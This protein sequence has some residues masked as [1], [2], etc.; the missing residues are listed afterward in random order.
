[1]VK[2]RMKNKQPIIWGCF[3]RLFGK[4]NW[5][6]QGLTQVVGFLLPKN[7]NNNMKYPQYKK[8]YDAMQADAKALYSID[9][10]EK[11]VERCLDDQKKYENDTTWHIITDPE[12]ETFMRKQLDYAEKNGATHNE[13]GTWWVEEPIKR[14]MIKG[15]H[16]SYLNN[17]ALQMHR[18]GLSPE[19]I[20]KI[21]KQSAPTF[22]DAYAMEMI[23]RVSPDIQASD[24][25]VDRPLPWEMYYRAMKRGGDQEYQGN[26]EKYTSSNSYIREVCGI[27]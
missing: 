3:I 15:L 19:A 24:S 25:W 4:P 5:R 21:M 8:Y 12:K 26:M 27:E 11:D 14:E 22:T 9:D 6:S 2:S 23:L 7:L 1:M 13:I 16:Q 17:K 20:M 10:F 18:S